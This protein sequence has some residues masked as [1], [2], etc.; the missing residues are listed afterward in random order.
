MIAIIE[1]LLCADHCAKHFTYFH[2]NLHRAEAD[3][4]L[5]F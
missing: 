1:S 3:D 4:L 5:L 2:P